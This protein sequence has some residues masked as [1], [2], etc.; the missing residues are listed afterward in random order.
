MTFT[1]TWDVS[2]GEF[3]IED[4][5]YFS[6]LS[7]LLAQEGITVRVT[8][9]LE[10]GF[11]ADALVLNYPEKPFTS[12]EVACL[13]AYVEQGGRLLA[14]AYYNN[15]DRVA[16]L[17]NALAEGFGV[18]FLY[19]GVQDP[20]HCLNGDPY[21]VLTR[22]VPGYPEIREVFLP[23]AAPIAVLKEAKVRVLAEAEA[24]ASSPSGVRVLATE[25]RYGKGTFVA[26]GTCVFWDNYAIDKAE[27]RIFAVRLL[28]GK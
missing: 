19:E 9:R 7:R 12:E 21:M 22:R 2:H 18:S 13:R 27:N 25:T 16:E 24:T 15:E 5:Y 20:I 4:G 8:H 14:L 26:V 17:L 6:A 10:D 23:Y 28:R 11:T 1:V 3:T